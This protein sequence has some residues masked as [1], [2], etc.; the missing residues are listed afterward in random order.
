MIAREPDQSA[1][2]T[3][4]PDR[5][6]VIAQVPDQSVVITRMPDRTEVIER[7]PDAVSACPDQLPWYHPSPLKVG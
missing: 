6:E 1:V 4:V 2:I 5:T 7:V 3:R